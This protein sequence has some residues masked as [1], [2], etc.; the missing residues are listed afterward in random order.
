MERTMLSS[1]YCIYKYTIQSV[2]ASII[3][4][5]NLDLLLTFGPTS[6]RDRVPKF[7]NGGGKG[8]RGGGEKGGKREGE[9]KK[10]GKREGEEK[11][12]GGEERFKFGSIVCSIVFLA[13][14]RTIFCFFWLF[15]RLARP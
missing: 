6:C 10:G 1:K 11:K 4:Y 9:E 14:E 2:C 15:C 7:E 12:E 3:L 5:V 13:R 8:G